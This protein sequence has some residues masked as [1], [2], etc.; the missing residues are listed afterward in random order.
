MEDYV[1]QLADVYDK[2]LTAHIG[3]SNFTK[4]HL[5]RALQLAGS[6]KLTPIRWKS[7]CSCRICPL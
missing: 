1:E 2:G 3:V 5:D 4:S 6:R 7:T